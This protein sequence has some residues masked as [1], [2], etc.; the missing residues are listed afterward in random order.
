MIE[1]GFSYANSTIKEMIAFF[2]TRVENLEPKEEKKISS[3][4]AKK[5]Q[6]KAKKRKREDSGSN[7]IESSE[8][9]STAHRP[10]KKYIFLYG[11]SSH[12]TDNCTNLRAIV[13]Q[14][15]RKRRKISGATEKLH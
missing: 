3:V 7:V 11:K 15:S 9:S 14:Q 4:A 8:E 6:K 13:N 1:Q 10:N 2:E 12:S 5:S